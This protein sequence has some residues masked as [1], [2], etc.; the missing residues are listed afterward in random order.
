MKGEA[1]IT[2]G[3]GD[4]YME[5]G[6]TVTANSNMAITPIIAGAVDVNTVGTYTITYTAVASSGNELKTQRV[7]HVKNIVYK[8]GPED[9]VSPWGLHLGRF[10][11]NA[12]SQT[13]T[14]TVNNFHMY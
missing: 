1:V 11:N 3:V 10:T 8:Y 5:K 13:L 7:V 4:T 6:A 14:L 9:F 2:L 12:T